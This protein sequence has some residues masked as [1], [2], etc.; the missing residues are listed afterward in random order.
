MH[1][2][3]EKIE[4]VINTHQRGIKK[5]IDEHRELIEFLQQEAPELIKAN[6]WVLGWLSSQDAFLVDLMNAS[7]VVLNPNEIKRGYPRP[8]PEAIKSEFRA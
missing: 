3:L 4:T 7:E 1:T 2:K 8:I 5:R 6:P